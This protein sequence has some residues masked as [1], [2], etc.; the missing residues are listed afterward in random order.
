[1]HWARGQGWALHGLLAVRADP[2]ASTR[3]GRLHT[4]LCAHEQDGR[5]RTI[6]DDPAAPI[7]NSLSALVAAAEVP[8][9]TDLRRRALAAAVASLDGD[10]GLPVSSATPVGP[11]ADYLARDTGVFPWG[12]GPLLLAL[13]SRELEERS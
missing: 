2:R 12:Q 5:W 13:L 4:A 7:E 1:V 8:Q 3:L 9:W 6:V 10:G 11:A